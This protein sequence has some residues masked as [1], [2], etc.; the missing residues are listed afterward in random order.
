[1][2]RELRRANASL[3]L[4][5]STNG[6]FMSRA[7]SEALV[8]SRANYLTVSLHG[9]HTHEGMM[10]YA[11]RGVDLEAIRRN[12]EELVELKARAG[13]KLPWIFLKAVLFDWNDS[14]E[15]MEAFLELGRGIGADFTG[16]DLNSGTEHS[17]RRVA[18]GTRAYRRLQERK[19]L[20]QNF[21]ELPAWP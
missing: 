21:Y 2:I 1:M 7:I 14:E 6:V 15:E 20:L 18:P 19:L 8:E 12:V 3:R 10:R 4:D 13:A 16:W 17:S 11:R 9:G 5:L